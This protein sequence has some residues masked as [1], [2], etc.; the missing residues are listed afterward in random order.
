MATSF[1]VQ[2]PVDMQPTKNSN[3][4][5]VGGVISNVAGVDAQ[6]STS[7]PSQYNPF[8]SLKMQQYQAQE[9]AV[10]EDT[11]TV[12]SQLAS[13]LAQDSP[14]MQRARTI[15]TQ[16]MN[17][18][19]LVNSSMA[20]GAGVAAM[21][22]RATPIAQQD[23]ETYSN[24][25]IANMR[26]VNTANQ[27]NVAQ[28]NTL[29]GQGVNVAAEY[30]RLKSQQEF[31]ASQAALNRAQQASLAAAA[32][33]FQAAQAELDRANQVALT[34]KSIAAN[35]ALQ[36]AQQNFTS[37]ENALD[38][39][40]QT[41]L[42]T[43]QQ[44]FTSG[45]NALDRSA[46]ASNLATQI[47][48]NQ[49]LQTGQQTFASEQN[50]LD[51][52]AS[53]SNL[54]TQ[55]AANQALQTGQQTFTSEQNALD[56]SA[57]A[58]NVDKQ[59][60]AN[61]VL[62]TANQTFQAT[63]SSLDRQAATDLA[64]LQSN[65]ANAAASTTFKANVALNTL[66]AINAV[67][68]DGNLDATAK[69]AAIQNITNAS[70]ATLNYAST[71]YSTETSATNSANTTNSASTAATNTST[72]TSTGPV[73]S[74]L[75]DAELVDAARRVASQSPDVNRDTLLNFAAANGISPERAERIA[76]EVFLSP[77]VLASEENVQ[78]GD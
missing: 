26:E 6:N 53:A 68:V 9:R 57:A 7:A 1:S 55:I 15:A 23:A 19:G 47:A 16:N 14:L 39:I 72:S 42:Q 78:G 43:G 12:K 45:Q 18:R 34:D 2:N 35:L 33:T 21:I 71:I 73:Y 44:T 36:K 64:T 13:I 50:A 30:A 8:A 31:E 76:N 48:A 41:T 28:N 67:A 24:R 20:Q 56:R 17:Q 66:N 77:L 3:N 27:F 63:Q 51:R 25:A 74:Q 11:E 61:Q 22:D 49:A 69:N 46:A 62:Q 75:S 5:I 37:A 60:T 29:L 38:R 10:N 70:N 32:Q 58:S 65:L 40:Q 54:A 59:I 4:G 52:T